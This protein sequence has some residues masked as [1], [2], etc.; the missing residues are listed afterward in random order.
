MTVMHRY[1]HADYLKREIHMLLLL[2]RTRLFVFCRDGERKCP[3]T[4]PPTFVN[5]ALAALA[6]VVMAFIAH[7]RRAGRSTWPVS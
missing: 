2:Q 4:P 5:T 1:I 7:E 3:H 6:E